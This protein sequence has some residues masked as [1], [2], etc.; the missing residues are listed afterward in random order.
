[1]VD[2]LASSNTSADRQEPFIGG[3][4]ATANRRGRKPRKSAGEALAARRRPA[5]LPML[6]IGVLVLILASI[7]GVIYSQRDL[8]ASLTG[9][10]PDVVEDQ[11]ESETASVDATPEEPQPQEEETDQSGKITDRLL[12]PEGEPPV[13]PDARS[14]TTTLITPGQT[15]TRLVEPEPPAAPV[16]VTPVV[17]ALPDAEPP[18]SEG[19]DTPAALSDG[20][21]EQQVSSI[22]PETATAP[23]D[24]VPSAQRSILYEEGAEASGAGTAAQ[25]AVVWSLEEE[26][27]LDG[28][29]QTVLTADV[30]IPERDVT[31][32]LR[33]K[34]NDDNSLPASHLVEI[35]YELPEEFASGTVVNVPGLVMKPTEEARGDALLGASVKV[36]EGYFWIALSSLSSEQERNLGLLRER[37]W[38]DI[39]MLYTNGKR[40]ILTLEK[41]PTGTDA[42]E[43]AIAAWT[44]G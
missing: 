16:D 22:A 8:I 25:G 21:A 40:G 3:A 2:N 35:K 43:K 4:D 26:T 36:S 30:E 41:G 7:A 37:G 20:Q 34:P 11:P 13:A 19:T 15:E 18:V 28:S 32:N 27:A 14:V 6:L 38:I 24:P 42:V 23:A 5:L 33:I 1:V 10:G 39:P 31:V 12:D 29:A 44:A 9:P 17:P